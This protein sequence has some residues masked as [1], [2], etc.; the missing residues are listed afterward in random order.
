[1]KKLNFNAGPAILPAAVM[2]EAAEA[3]RE[4]NGSGL[5][6]LE[7]S[8]R[9]PE[10]EAIIAEARQLVKDLYRLPDD[11]DVLFLQGGAS[12]QFLMVPFNLL[13]EAGTASY[14][15]TGGWA[16][17]AIKEAKGLGKVHISASSKEQNYNHIPKDVTIAEGSAYFHITTNNTLYG[18]E[19]NELSRLRAALAPAPKGEANASARDAVPPRLTDG[20]ALGGK[21]AGIGIPVVADMSSNIFS[22][23]VDATQFDL[24]Y[25]GAQKNIGPAGATI[26]AVRKSLLG[27]TG[28]K[29]PTM[30]DYQVHIDNDSM[31]NTPSCFAVYVCMLTMR[32]LKRIGGMEAIGKHN[33]EKA[34]LL[35][36]AIDNNE[37]FVGTAAKEDRSRMN[38]TFLLKDSSRDKEFLEMCEEAGIVG[39]K[40]HRSV[41]GFR[42]SIY[43][44]MPLEHV[45]VLTEVMAEFAVHA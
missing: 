35:Y 14:M 26:V 36:D 32:W 34:K 7:M 25:A 21:G 37:L 22:G 3:V 12:L 18:T 5:S 11:Y 38:V 45:K 41:G 17:K 30:L 28:R 29:I 4:L 20:Q 27:K 10:F 40:G 24:I 39:I 33:E 1:M 31:F 44:A 15:D 19:I 13:P 43:N 9:S 2:E 6:I 16:N 8:H 23:P 42:A